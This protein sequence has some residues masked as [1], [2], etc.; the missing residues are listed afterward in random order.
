MKVPST[1]GTKV[2]VPMKLAR[3]MTV[4][5]SVSAEAEA[6]RRHFRVSGAA[7]QLTIPV[8]SN[9]AQR[10]NHSLNMRNDARIQRLVQRSRLRIRRE[11]FGAHLGDGI[12]KLILKR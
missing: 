2:Y 1:T 10:S 3:P 7:S 6:E 9:L 5:A 12:V 4:S 8:S 11:D